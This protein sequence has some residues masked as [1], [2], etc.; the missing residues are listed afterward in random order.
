M[1]ESQ[2][3]ATQTSVAPPPPPGIAPLPSGP[4]WTKI[5]LAVS[6]ALN[7]AVAG[8]AAGAFLKVGHGHGMPHKLSFGPFSA[9]LTSEDRRALRQALIDRAPDFREARAQSRAEF[10]TLLDTL[11]A[12]P[13]DRTALQSALVAIEV[14][15]ADRLELGRTLIETRILQMSET[16]RLAFAERLEKGLRWRD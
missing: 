15:N 1:T 16:D 3:P 14:R 13:L 6:V 12:S 5:A 8:L 10:V 11:R 9:A 2:T 4:N 7:L